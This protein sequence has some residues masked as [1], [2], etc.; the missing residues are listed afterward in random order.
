MDLN[1]H[2]GVLCKRGGEV[3]CNRFPYSVVQVMVGLGTCTVGADR[4]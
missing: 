1:A 2:G 4:A 3:L